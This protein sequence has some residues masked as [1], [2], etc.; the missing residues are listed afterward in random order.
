MATRPRSP[1]PSPTIFRTGR[2]R[3][4][5]WLPLPQWAP[6]PRPLAL[7]LDRRAAHRPLAASRRT[8]LR[9]SPRGHRRRCEISLN[10]AQ[11]ALALYKNA[12][13][14]PG[15][16]R[17]EYA[18]TYAYQRL[19]REMECND[20]ATI[21][22]R[23]PHGTEYSLLR[24][25][26]L[27]QDSICKVRRGGLSSAERAISGAETLTAMMRLPALGLYVVTVQTSLF[28]DS[29]RLAAAFQTDVSGLSSCSKGPCNPTRRYGLLYYM[30]SEAQELGLPFTA[31]HIMKS[32][33]AVAVGFKDAVT[34]A[35]ALET[36]A[37]L[38]GR[39]GDFQASKSAFAEA[40]RIAR[41][42]DQAALGKI[43]SI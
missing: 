14:I 22:E 11:Q 27:V 12:G 24:A 7:G 31:Q 36:L 16:L 42:G 5:S 38:A 13:N 26:N 43:L 2:R 34:R 30:V 4:R 28:E 17:A 9:V 23:D 21:V 18:E 37:S 32:A 10:E 6:P 3:G 41:E 35:Y 25:Q 15:R 8:S 19:G 29:G 1:T 39:N 40:Q 33:V 20:G